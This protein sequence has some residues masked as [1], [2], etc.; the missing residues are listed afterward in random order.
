MGISY[1]LAYTGIHILYPFE[2][3]VSLRD[4]FEKAYLLGRKY[5]L[6]PIL[7]FAA[8]GLLNDQQYGL[9]GPPALLYV[10]AACPW[11]AYIEL[12]KIRKKHRV[13]F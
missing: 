6:P 4:R 11:L 12:Y 13:R 9:F 10:F 2:V 1:S 7:V 3:K 8:L 5:G